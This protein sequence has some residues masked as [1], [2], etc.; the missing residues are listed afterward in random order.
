MAATVSIHRHRRQNTER[1]M[2]RQRKKRCQMELK[3]GSSR[4]RDRGK[5][6]L[7]ICLVR[8]EL[9]CTFLL[10]LNW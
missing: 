5:V 7:A 9:T 3:K 6:L 8:A 2:A 10:L 4:L 1:F